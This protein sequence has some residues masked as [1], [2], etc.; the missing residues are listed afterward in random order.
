MDKVKHDAKTARSYGQFCGLA[1][2]LDVVGDRWTLLIVRE[3]LPGPMRYTELKTSLTG[4]ATNLLADRL[5]TME[6]NGIVER[7]L[8]ESGVAYALTPRGADLREPMEALGRWGTPLLMTGRGDDTFRP[9]WLTLALPALL[10]GVTATPPVELGIEMDGFLMVLRVDED[11]P[12]AFV[13]PDQP[14]TIFSAAPDIVI[15][16]AAGGITIDRALA[17]GNLQGDERILREAFSPDDRRGHPL[18]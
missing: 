5:R 15:G 7:R 3:L 10:R 11:G 9:R 16:L 14:G 17:L 4:I 8:E 6:V 2:S 1:R 12:S 13:P 18:G